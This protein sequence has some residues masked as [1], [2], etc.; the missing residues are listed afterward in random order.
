MVPASSAV[1][2]PPQATG[3]RIISDAGS[4]QR[5]RARCTCGVLRDE[6]SG[7]Q[8]LA[9]AR[10]SEEER[11]ANPRAHELC[12]RERARGPL[13]PNGQSPSGP[14]TPRVAPLRFAPVRF[15]PTLA[16]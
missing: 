8:T 13:P 11:A 1:S 3:A 9:E 12:F 10:Q 14:P 5:S 6:D 2:S 16:A 7:G 15:A 4:K